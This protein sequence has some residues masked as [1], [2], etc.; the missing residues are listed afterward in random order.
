MSVRVCN[1]TAGR[2]KIF[3]TAAVLI[4]FKY[5]IPFCIYFV[6]YVFLCIFIQKKCIAHVYYVYITKQ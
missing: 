5:F 4:R 2:R 1:N 6:N 3:K